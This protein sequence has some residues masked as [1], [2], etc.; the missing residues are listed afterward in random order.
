[1]TMKFLVAYNG[2]AESKAALDLAARHAS[3][4]KAK[5]YVIT[6]MEGGH[7]EKPED[8]ARVTQELKRVRDHLETSGVAHEVHEMARGLSPGEDI[9]IFAE[10]NSIDQ[11]FVGI[12]KKSRTRKLLLGSTA[13]YIILKATCPVTTIK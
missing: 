12:E 4:F 7:S 8:I 11:I 2:S 9:V 6:S 10:E 3:L 1:M 13:Q 5:V